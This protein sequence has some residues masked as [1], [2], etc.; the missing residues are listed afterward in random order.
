MD[1]AVFEMKD[2]LGQERRPFDREGIGPPVKPPQDAL[3]SRQGVKRCGKG[4]ARL[5]QVRVKEVKETRLNHCRG[6]V[7]VIDQ[8]LK[9]LL[10]Y[11]KGTSHEGI[12]PIG[13]HGRYS[14]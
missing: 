6:I 1:K 11:G 2:S 14:V 3:F 4:K 9:P 13:C 7:K 8:Y 12:K 10:Q 5:Y